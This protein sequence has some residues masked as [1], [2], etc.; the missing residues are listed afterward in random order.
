[1]D[2]IFDTI[3][4]ILFNLFIIVIDLLI[5]KAVLSS[6]DRYNQFINIRTLIS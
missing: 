2:F 5:A 4:D 3:G 1:M 6:N